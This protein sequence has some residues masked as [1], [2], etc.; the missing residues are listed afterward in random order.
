MEGLEVE[1][2]PGQ[3]H[4]GARLAMRVRNGAGHIGELQAWDLDAGERVWS[5]TFESHNVGLILTTAGGL[6]F[7]GGTSD[8]FFRA[9]DAE[10]GEELW[11]IRT[12]FG[13]IGVPM[14]FAVD[15][16][17]YITVQSGWGARAQRLQHHIDRFR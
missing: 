10:T 13:V 14:S 2:I 5:R 1:H 16:R 9:F 4:V 12:N 7:M 8:R 6:V 15:G 17:Q 3:Q 11:R